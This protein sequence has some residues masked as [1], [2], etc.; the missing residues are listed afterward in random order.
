MTEKWK[1]SSL[2]NKYW[3][4][5]PWYEKFK[6]QHENLII[7]KLLNDSFDTK[8]M[9]TNNWYWEKTYTLMNSNRWCSLTEN[10][11]TT[12]KRKICVLLLYKTCICLERDEKICVWRYPIQKSFRKTSIYWT[13]IVNVTGSYQR[14]W[15]KN[16]PKVLKHYMGSRE[17]VT[18]LNSIRS[19]FI[20]KFKFTKMQCSCI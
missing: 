13:Q 15:F 4:I 8:V 11:T 1:R 5:T 10:K 18:V 20:R 16:S 6:A 19:D 2:K 7:S 9:V 3:L 14:W 17:Y 12:S